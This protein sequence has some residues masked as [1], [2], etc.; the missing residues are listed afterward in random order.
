MFTP[1]DGSAP[2]KVEAKIT[3]ETT[4]PTTDSEGKTVYTATVTGPDGKTYTS[5]KEVVIPKLPYLT[6]LNIGDINND[7]KVTAADARLALRAAVGLEDL[8]KID[9]KAVLRGNV[10]FK[11]GVT[12][13]DARL[14]LRAAVG[15]EDREKW[16]KNA[17]PVA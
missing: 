14:I 7:G 16:M 13:A 15:L 6:A 10:D 5:V 17:P 3:S 9:D 4:A 2:V 1:K 8:T 12:A 11:D